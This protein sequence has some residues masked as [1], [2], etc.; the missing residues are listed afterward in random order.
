MSIST[1]IKDMGIK[2]G[3]RVVYTI[4]LDNPALSNPQKVEL[5]NYCNEYVNNTLRNRMPIPTPPTPAPTP[6]ASNVLLAYNFDKP[7]TLKDG[8]KSPDGELLCQ[9]LGYGYGTSGNSYLEM[10]P[11]AVTSKDKTSACFVLTEKTFK[12][13]KLTV[14]MMTVAHTRLNTPP[15]GWETAWLMFNYTDKYHH[16]YL[17]LGKSG[18]FEL[19]KK[20]YTPVGTNSIKTPDGITHQNVGLDNQAFLYTKSNAVQFAL[21]RWF[22]IDLTVKDFRFTVAVDGVTIAD[23]TDNGSTG[24]MFNTPINYKPSP[25]MASGKI[26]LYAEDSKVRFRNLKVTQN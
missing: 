17:Y 9:Y 24:N 2:L 3:K 5:A 8:Q 15:N 1:T 13:F 6:T 4:D 11:Q 26:G 25:I 21:G 23:I 19:G 10:A 16:N 7:W 18:L 22:S 14:D 12:N 20:D